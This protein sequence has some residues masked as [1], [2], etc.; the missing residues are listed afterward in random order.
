MYNSPYLIRTLPVIRPDF[1]C[2]DQIVKYYLFVPLKKG[3]P[4][5]MTTF[6]L[7]KLFPGDKKLMI[8]LWTSC[9]TVKHVWIESWIKLESC[10]N[11]IPVY[12][13]HKICSVYRGFTVFVNIMYPDN[14]NAWLLQNNWIDPF[15]T[16]GSKISDQYVQNKRTECQKKICFLF[17][18]VEHLL[19]IWFLSPNFTYLKGTI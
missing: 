1:E 19:F 13:E 16:S 5:Y 8:K 12:S 17:L 14:S 4:S 7:Q 18:Y 10:I 9:R 6:S 2:T 15:V 3:H 11:C